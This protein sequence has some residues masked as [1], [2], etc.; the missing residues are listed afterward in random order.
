M[1][2]IDFSQFRKLEVQEKVAA[3]LFSPEASL[4]G[5]KVIT[6]LFLYMVFPQSACV[7]GLFLF[8]RTAF[9]LD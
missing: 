6:F 3:G 1:I 5:L 4:L 8:I 7:C 9:I 2:Q